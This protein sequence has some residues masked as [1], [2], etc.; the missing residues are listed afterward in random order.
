MDTDRIA[1]SA[2][3]IVG[4]IKERVGRLFGDRKTEAEGTAQ[5]TEGKVQNTVGGVKDTVRETVD[6]HNH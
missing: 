6:S 3:Q 1:G 5:R 2:K 4:T